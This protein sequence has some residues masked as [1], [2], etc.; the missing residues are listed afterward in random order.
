[1]NDTSIP[2][3]DSIKEL[4][5]FWDTHDLTDF[6]DEL[7]EVS[8]SVFERQEGTVVTIRERRGAMEFKN[9]ANAIKFNVEKGAD[10]ATFGY[11]KEKNTINLFYQDNTQINITIP[12]FTTSPLDASVVN[13]RIQDVIERK[14]NTLSEDVKKLRPEE[15]AT[16]FLGTTAASLASSATYMTTGNVVDMKI[17]KDPE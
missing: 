16:Y 8:G 5:R 10:E 11:K 15:F 6:E 9:E 13:Q 1:M 7:E 12:V 4:A 17:V 2:Q 3:T 14:A